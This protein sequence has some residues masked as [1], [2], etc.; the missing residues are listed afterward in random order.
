MKRILKNFAL[1]L[2]HKLEIFQLAKNV[3]LQIKIPVRD[4]SIKHID[5]A[6]SRDRK[7]PF[8]TNDSLILPENVDE[9]QHSSNV[10]L[11]QK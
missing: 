5:I 3:S 11:K 1:T 9:T 2:N 10:F 7:G 6:D 8:S 4:D